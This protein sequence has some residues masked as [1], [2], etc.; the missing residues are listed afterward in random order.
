M[1][2]LPKSPKAAKNRAKQLRKSADSM[3]K[4]ATLL[5]KRQHEK[6]KKSGCRQVTVCTRKKGKKAAKVKEGVE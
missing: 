4:R 6:Q 1:A 5:E 3:D 2:K